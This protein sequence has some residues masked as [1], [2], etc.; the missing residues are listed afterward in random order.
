MR[1]LNTVTFVFLFPVAM[2]NPIVD[3][4][5]KIDGTDMKKLADVVCNSNCA[6]PGDYYRQQTILQ[7]C[8]AQ[9]HTVPCAGAGR[10]LPVV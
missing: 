4:N 1:L 8:Q 5:V 7:F 9:G 10:Q 2:C 6:C 3:I